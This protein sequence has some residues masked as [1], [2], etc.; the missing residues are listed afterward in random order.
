MVMQIE[1]PGPIRKPLPLTPLV[2]VVFLL[3]MFFLLTSTFTKFGHMT[4]ESS[5]VGPDQSS[6]TAEKAP[7]MPGVV[8]RVARGPNLQV[9]GRYIELAGLPAELNAY[10]AKGVSR[11]VLVAAPGATVQDLVTV[12]EAGR[13]SHI[14]NILIA[15]SAGP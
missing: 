7:A 12:L 13:T 11:A 9:N 6:A 1:E 15:R 5:G 3:L 8:L 4:L 2:D 14:G 10:E